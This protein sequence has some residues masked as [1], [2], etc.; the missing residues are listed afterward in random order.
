[1]NRPDRKTIEQFWPDA[2]SKLDK[3]FARKK[4][5]KRR[6]I[7]GFAG[8]VV[9][10][11]TFAILWIKNGNVSQKL[12]NNQ[13]VINMTSSN[14][15]ELNRIIGAQKAEE[16]KNS[17][18]DFKDAEKSSSLE[19]SSQ[20]FSKHSD[21]R[22][23]VSA[24]RSKIPTKI[25]SQLLNPNESIKNYSTKREVEDATSSG[26]QMRKQDAGGVE[27]GAEV[28]DG[29][30]KKDVVYTDYGKEVISQLEEQDIKLV[31][32][33]DGF[34]DV[35]LNRG[36]AV[37]QDT[38]ESNGEKQFTYL[39]DRILVDSVN[40]LKGTSNSNTAK[41]EAT[42]F[43]GIVPELGIQP[44]EKW[45]FS[46]VPSIGIFNVRKQLVGSVNEGEYLLRRKQEELRAYRESARLGFE[47]S[48]NRI[49]IQTGLYYSVYGERTAYSN[50]LY[51]NLPHIQLNTETTF[52]TTVSITSVVDMGNS[53]QIVTTNIET[54]SI[55]FADT[56]MVTTQ[57]NINAVP[58]QVQNRI[59]YFELPF[60]LRYT[61]YRNAFVDVGI[62][63][64]GS[65]GIL[66]R[67][68]GYV[69]N[70]ELNEFVQLD[71]EAGLQKIIGNARIAADVRFK[72]SEHLQI[73]LRSEWSTTVSSVL[74]QNSIR[75]NYQNWGMLLEVKRT[76]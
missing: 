41:I 51:R 48:K 38:A 54:N 23:I 66:W 60:A 52:D 16:N 18:E 36:L 25:T 46:L 59:R 73:G 4:L 74:R 29:W 6:K 61:A 67:S 58:Y 31:R 44:H 33:E 68:R 49:S 40:V 1:M 21:E 53:Y 75:Q 32:N 26:E 50:W 56:V 37:L 7:A 45:E 65:L 8:L 43:G 69:V 34:E 30:P 71:T 12:V 64:G 72:L 3:H 5:I 10:V 9:V 14:K 35:K 55:T 62:S 15:A 27:I 22:N 42:L 57:T 76:F 2:S 17:L 24:Q 63:A 11:A 39:T 19:D 28:Q 20:P 13:K 47:I 70:S